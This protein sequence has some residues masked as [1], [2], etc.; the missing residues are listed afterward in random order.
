[1]PLRNGTVFC[2]NHGDIPMVRNTGFNAVIRLDV[3]DSGYTFLPGSGVPLVVYYCNECGYVE[4][5]AAQ[6]T[7]FWKA[8][9]ASSGIERARKFEESVIHA[10]ESPDSPL[11]NGEVSREALLVAG[12]KRYVADAIVKTKEGIYVVEAKGQT[13]K[14]TLESAAAQV[15]NF[16]DLYRQLGAEDTKDRPILP[17]V[18]TPA[19]VTVPD[20]VLGVP[21]LQFDAEKKVFSN[22]EAILRKLHNQAEHDLASTT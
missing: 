5:Y 7:P 14:R 20:E 13:S 22:G 12:N 16:V 18:I 19:E 6:K 11:G 10:I 2:L 15:R 3:T 1:M 4:S 9:E 8:P 17:L 21:V